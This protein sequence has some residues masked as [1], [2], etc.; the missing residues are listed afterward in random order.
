MAD[1]SLDRKLQ[2]E[3]EDSLKTAEA[4]R[5]EARAKIDAAKAALVQTQADSAK[6]KAAEA[7]ARA[8]R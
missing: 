7:V 1:G 2:D 3:T 4:A 5:G 6:V 8:A